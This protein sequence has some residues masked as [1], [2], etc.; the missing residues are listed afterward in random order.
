MPENV[1]GRVWFVLKSF[2][3]LAIS[4]SVASALSIAPAAFAI[5]AGADASTDASARFDASDGA[6]SRRD[7]TV[8]LA[9]PTYTVGK[10]CK[11]DG[12]CAAG[13]TCLTPDTDSLAAGGPAGGLCTVLCT[14][15]G[16]D[17]CDR[18]DTASFCV[19]EPTGS[20]QFCAETCALGAVDAGVAKCHDRDDMACSPT[21]TGSGGY[22]SPTCRGDFDCGDGRVCEPRTGLCTKSLAGTLPLGSPCDPTD[23]VSDCVGICVPLGDGAPTK[24]SSFC[25]MNCALGREDACGKNSTTPGVTL[26]QCVFGFDSSERTGD[27]GDCGQV[28]DCDSDCVNPAFVCSPNNTRVTGHAGVCVPRLTFNGVTPGTSCGAGKPK[29]V[30]DA[31]VTA[32][33]DAGTDGGTAIKA[34]GGCS[35]RTTSREP[36]RGAIALFGLAVAT[37]GLRRRTCTARKPG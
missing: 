4:A 21:Q 37:L 12:D 11:K 23:Q 34:T 30:K 27:V 35:C 29:L 24:D 2:R 36:S 18:V 17:D 6:S 28:C 9:P 32:A 8:P 16:Q 14:T 5:D 31:G 3:W 1:S 7:A 26:A 10:S 33:A 25:S 20:V 22:C 15:N 13:L 19:S